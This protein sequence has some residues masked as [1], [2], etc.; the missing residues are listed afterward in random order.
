M[1]TIIGIRE[2]WM[3]YLASLLQVTVH[4]YLIRL[5]Q[6]LNEFE[7]CLEQSSE[8]GKNSINSALVTVCV[9]LCC[10]TGELAVFEDKE[11]LI[12]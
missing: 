2:P 10:V 7:K 4:N 6:G 1:S 11:S 3:G 5:R 12:I 8:H 9:V